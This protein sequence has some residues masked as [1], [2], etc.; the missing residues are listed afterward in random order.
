MT[1]HSAATRSEEGFVM[2][3]MIVLVLIGLLAATAAVTSSLVTR[4]TATHEARV[5]RAQQ[6]AEGGVQQQLYDQS[7]QNI[8][9]DYNFSGGPFGLSG[10]VDCAVPQLNASLQITGLSAYASSAGVCPLAIKCISTCTPITSNNWT[11]LDNHAYYESEMLTNKKEVS[12]S[13]FGAVV[14]F[15]EIVSIGCDTPTPTTT[16][17]NGGSSSNVYS[18]EAVLMAPTGPISAIEGMGNVTIAG[19][20]V[21]GVNAAGVVNGDVMADGNLTIPAVGIAVNTGWPATGILPTFGYGGSVSASITTANL[22]HLTGGFCS[23]GSPGTSCIIKRPPPQTT[24]T[25]CGTTCSTGITCSSCT[26]AG[27]NSTKDTFTITGGTAT[28]AG[29]DYVFCNFS[30]TGSATLKASASSSTPV[31]I[32]ILPPNS[33]A[34]S[35]NGF[36]ETS[37][38]WNGGNFTDTGSG[39]LT[40]SL[41]G[42]VNGVT[43]TV[44][45]SGLQIYAEGDG[46]Y[47]NATSVTIGSSSQTSA[48]SIGAVVYAPASTVTVNASASI[49]GTTLNGTFAGNVVGDNV[50]ISASVI[51]QDLDI[52]NYPI[53]TGANTYRPQQYIQCDTSV[54]ALTNA[55]ADTNGC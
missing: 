13:G 43:N 20:K 51:T 34:C 50:S 39:G 29:G 37:G 33:S 11:P 7:D 16:P 31:R 24:A 41:L 14:E 52:G 12:G 8:A 54:T 35:S 32:F 47:D 3:V 36:T 1:R 4:Q 10:F 19:L 18:R 53:E 40:N 26:G 22:V 30:A 48:L 46:G 5:G 49:L 45:P 9:A 55:S 21:L 27:Y 25:S 6:A 17:C 2:V 42:T 23:A 28:F 38:A 44:D 15:P